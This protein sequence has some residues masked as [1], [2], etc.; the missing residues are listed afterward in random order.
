MLVA[1]AIAPHAGQC[2]VFPRFEDYSCK[3]F[4]HEQ[5]RTSDPLFPIKLRT[6][7]GAYVV[8]T[9]GGPIRLTP[10]TSVESVE[11]GQTVVTTVTCDAIEASN[12]E[13]LPAVLLKKQ[14]KGGPVISGTYFYAQS[15]GV[16]RMDFGLRR[17]IP[18]VKDGTPGLIK[19]NSCSVVPPTHPQPR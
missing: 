14:V 13:V 7:N 3:T 4:N 11:N 2:P 18:G 19:K 10:G 1:S 12:H 8:T 16:V 6:E 9:T 15:G 17:N 5:K